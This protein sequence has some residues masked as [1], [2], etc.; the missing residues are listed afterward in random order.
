[1]TPTKISVHSINNVLVGLAELPPCGTASASVIPVPG[2]GRI[3]L[4]SADVLARVSTLLGVSSQDSN[5]FAQRRQKEFLRRAG[6]VVSRQYAEGQ[7]LPPVQSLGDA[8]GA[9]V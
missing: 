9:S 8:P 3:L 2:G 4:D 7:S 6:R 5:P 1:M